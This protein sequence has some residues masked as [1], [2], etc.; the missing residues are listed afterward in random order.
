L[1]VLILYYAIDLEYLESEADMMSAYYVDPKYLESALFKM[2]IM[3][4][5][6]RKPLFERIRCLIPR[7]H[8]A[9][10]KRILQMERA[11]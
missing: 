11:S 3:K 5:N 10:E 2:K 9:F 1:F 6:L 7:A 4:Y 8:P